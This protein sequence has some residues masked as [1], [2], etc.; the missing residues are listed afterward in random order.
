M[1]KKL[2]IL[3]ITFNRKEE[4]LK[5]LEAIRIYQPH[6]LYI[7]SDGPRELIKGE[8]DLVKNIRNSILKM[9]DWDC[10]IVEIFHKKNLG[11]KNAVENAIDSF[12]SKEKEGIIL[13]DDCLPCQSFFKFC[14]KYLD[15]YENNT[16]VGIISGNNFFED[17]GNKTECFF[18]E[19]P[20]IWGWATWSS[21]WKNHRKFFEENF[22]KRKKFLHKD[23]KVRFNIPYNAKLA[24]D[25]QINTWDYQFIYSQYFNEQLTLVPRLNLVQN[26]GFS[27]NAT[28]TAN[29]NSILLSRTSK[30]MEVYGVE[31]IDLN[32]NLLYDQEVYRTIFKWSIFKTIIKMILK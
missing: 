20:F 12:F 26:I 7:S 6:R 16:R 1:N 22:S 19:Y 21:T 14:E 2:P 24:V 32:P 31:S 23:L 18:S 15:I 29:S 10:E 25:K 28:H 3:F 5:V 30:D 13:E 8:I 11:C 4:S 9:I 17:L 27:D